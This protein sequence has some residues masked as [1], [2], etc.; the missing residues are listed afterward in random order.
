MTG[1]PTCILTHTKDPDRLRPARHGLLCIGHYKRLE[2]LLAE[3]P[4]RLDEADRSLVPG[5]QSGPKVSGDPETALP[6]NEHLSR[7]MHQTRD[8]LASWAAEVVE[9]HPDRL[10]P[11]MF[12]ATACSAFL[13][14]WLP[15]ISEQEWVSDFH[16]ETR[17]NAQQLH[18][19]LEP[20]RTRRVDLGPCD[21]KTA[22]D[23]ESHEEMT[24]QGAMQAVVRDT[25]EN[26][27]AEITC[28]VCGLVNPP[29]EWR[30]LARRL[31]GTQDPMLTAAQLSQLLRVPV[32]TL[33]RWASEDDWRRVEDVTENGR[34]TRYSVEDAQATHDRHQPRKD[35]AS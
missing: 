1:Y 6:F 24:C 33:W 22:C 5:S 19:A 35:V 15:W 32:G 4:A 21:A 14:R 16:D 11:P 10:H 26:L 34:R 8:T 3:I 9:Q 29:S 20:L 30:A 18:A 25:D 27:P 2:Q 13:L 7:A 23:V 28:T 17:E 31:R 12:T